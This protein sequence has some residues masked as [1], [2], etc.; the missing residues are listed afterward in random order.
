M[1]RGSGCKKTPCEPLH[2]LTVPDMS[3]TLGQPSVR[4]GLLL[5]ADV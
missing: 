1:V 2:L 4:Q 5:S 3:R